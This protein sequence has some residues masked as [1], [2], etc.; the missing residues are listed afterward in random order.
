MG[1]AF[2][3][4]TTLAPTR[5]F[6]DVGEE[7]RVTVVLPDY[8]SNPVT[9]RIPQEAGGLLTA[10]ATGFGSEE[11]AYEAG[12]QMQSAIRAACMT[13]GMAIDVGTEPKLQS[14]LSPQ[15]REAMEHQAIQSGQ[16]VRVVNYVHGVQVFHDGDLP[17]RYFKVGAVGIVETGYT[18]FSDV[19]RLEAS[20]Q[21]AAHPVDR[22]LETARDLFM[23]ADMEQS[24]RSRFL[25]LVTALEV[26]TVRHTRSHELQVHIDS[27][28]ASTKEAR[29]PAAN[30]DEMS[31]LIDALGRERE[32]SITSAI[33]ELA[34]S[35][36]EF[37]DDDADGAARTAAD[38]YAARST[39]V[40]DGVEPQSFDINAAT[41]W[42]RNLVR[43]LVL[44]K[45]S[46]ATPGEIRG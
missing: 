11:D 40:H 6:H 29:R 39:I 43:A 37:G 21:T 3:L 32:Q 17:V 41:N 10:F 38:Y 25:I 33:K 30:P 44:P 16:P 8:P 35:A 7:E 1:I 23:A 4:A 31:A 15:A 36:P 18:G 14:A 20:R 22:K 46:D 13:T 2:L 24:S 45:P 27:L 34:R 42:V 9:V 26:L 19:L 28:I 12:R 5:K